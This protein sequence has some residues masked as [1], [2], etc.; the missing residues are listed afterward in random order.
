MSV[1]HAVRCVAREGTRARLELV[2]IHPDAMGRRRAFSIGPFF[3]LQLLFDQ[4][5]KDRERALPADD[6]SDARERAIAALAGELI[7]NIEILSIA[8]EGITEDEFEYAFAAVKKEIGDE[9]E[10][11][12]EQDTGLPRVK[13]DVEAADAATFDDLSIGVA[14]ESAAYDW[15]PPPP[16]DERV[17]VFVI[18]DEVAGARARF[19]V[20]FD[21][22]YQL[23]GEGGKPTIPLEVD[24]WFA[25]RVLVDNEYSQLGQALREDREDI[26]QVNGAVAGALAKRYI[27]SARVREPLATDPVLEVEVTDPCHLA[28]IEPADE[29]TAFAT[30]LGAPRLVPPGSIA[31]LHRPSRR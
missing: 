21:W 10:S 11:F 28:G 14:W 6:S 2:T 5:L 15:A 22:P 31:G 4:I 25:L 20:Y 12:L 16:A 17:R 29:W 23:F 30:L 8:N 19:R 3:V 27:A 18:C 9:G 7:T 13:F 26:E 24:D 1:L